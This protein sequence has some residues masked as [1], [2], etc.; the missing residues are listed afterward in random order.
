MLEDILW[1]APKESIYCLGGNRL[2]RNQYREIGS[3]PFLPRIAGPF[4]DS[5]SEGP[6]PQP[7]FSN[8]A[9][10]K[11]AL[12]THISHQTLRCSPEDFRKSILTEK[13]V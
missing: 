5:E 1:P 9:L 6:L 8:M 10:D 12:S 13:F 11:S 3:F 7:E 4:L 2:S